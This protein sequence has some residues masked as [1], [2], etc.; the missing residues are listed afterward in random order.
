MITVTKNFIWAKKGALEDLGNRTELFWESQHKY[1][2][3]RKNNFKGPGKI[4]PETTDSIISRKI[5]SIRRW[6]EE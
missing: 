1:V 5:K 6:R 3:P 2:F 4:W